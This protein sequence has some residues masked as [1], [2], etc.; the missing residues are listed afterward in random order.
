VRSRV[1]HLDYLDRGELNAVMRSAEAV[2]FPSLLEGFGLPV[3]EAM[4]VGVP[5]ITSNVSS[6]PEVGGDAVLYVDPRDPADIAAA[7]VRLSGDGELRLALV[8]S[9]RKRAALFRW[10]EAARATAGVLRRVA[11]MPERYADAYRV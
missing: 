3:V 11:G 1:H 4:A 10:D 7:I 8:E 9:G 6:L 2:V 5:V